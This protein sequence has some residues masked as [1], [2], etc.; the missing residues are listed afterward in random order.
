MPIDGIAR[1]FRTMLRLLVAGLAVG[2]VCPQSVAIGS[3]KSGIELISSG[4]SRVVFETTIEAYTLKPSARLENTMDLMVPGFATLSRPGEPRLPARKFLVALPPEG[5]YTVRASVLQEKSLGT[6]ILEPVAFPHIEH[7][8]YTQ[9]L[10]TEEYSIDES[11][12]RAYANKAT[13]LPD[14]A[15]FLRHQRVL[16][17]WINP[18]RYDP[19]SGALTLATKIRIEVV[20]SGSRSGEASAR[21]EPVVEQPGWNRILSR[22]LVNPDAP[23]SWRIKERRFSAPASG[24]G[25]R[26]HLLPPGPLLKIQVR[27]TGMHRIRASVLAAQGFPSGTATENLRLFK[28]QYDADTMEENYIDVPVAVRE[29]PGGTP[30]VFDGGDYLLFYGLRLRDDPLQG[31]PIEKFSD[32]NVYW[33][34]ADAGAAMQPVA[35]RSGFVS[36]D[37]SLVSFNVSDRYEEDHGFLEQTPKPAEGEPLLQQ[38]SYYFN[39]GYQ[40]SFQLPFTVPAIRSGSSVLVRIELTGGVLSE[41]SLRELVL[42]IVNSKG[43][44]PLNSIYVSGNNK[45]SYVSQPVPAAAIDIGTNTLR[46]LPE[47][48]KTQVEAF[49]NRFYI[50]YVSPYRARGSMLK[51]DT[52]SLAGDTSVTVTGLSRTDLLLFDV[53]DPFGARRCVLT[54]DLFTGTGGDTILS[55]RDA[56]AARKRYIL[57]PFDAIEEIGSSD[58]VSDTPSAIIGNPMEHG[59]DVLVVSHRDFMNEMQRWVGYRRAQGY[60]VFMVDVAELFDEFNGGV[61]NANAV[62]RFIEHYYRKADASVVLLVGD[63]S[64]D[65]K[66]VLPKSGP[67][68]VPTQSYPERT[69]SYPFNEDGVV[70]TDKW[71]VLMNN[72]FLAGQNDYYPDLLIGR[73]PAGDVRELQAML[74]KVFAFEKPG[75]SDF[76]R[77]RMIQVADDAW[78]GDL[79]TTCF[80]SSELGFEAGED[81]VEQIIE[82]SLAGG[83]DIVSA[84]LSNYTSI[85]HPVN[86]GCMSAYDARRF[87]RTQATPGL[88]AELSQGATLV[89]IQAHM[90][91]YLITHEEFFT[92]SQSTSTADGGQDHRRLQNFFKPFVVFGMGCHMSDYAANNELAR[93]QFNDANGD[94][95]DEL[96]LFLANRGAVS[97]YGSSGFE[98]LGENVVYTQRIFDTFFNNPPVD[99]MIA[100]NRAQARWIFGELMAVSEVTGATRG[101]LVRYHILGDPLL[102]IDAGPPRFSVTVNGT[103]VSSG[104]LVRTGSLNDTIHV[105][106]VVS[107]ENAID[108]L[109]LVIDGIDRSETL[110]EVPLVDGGLSA[111]RQYRVTFAHK[112][113]PKSYDIVLRALQ[114]PDTVS[115]QYNMAAEFTLTVPLDVTFQVNGRGIVDGDL[116]PIE[117]AYTVT[118]RVPVAVDAG[119]LGVSVDDV[120]VAP[121]TVNHPSPEDTTSWI[122]GFTKSLEAGEHT[123]AVS[124]AG[125]EIKHIAV[126]VSLERGIAEL[127]PYPNP[128]ST[129]AYFVFR[130]E[131]EIT[132]GRIEIFTTSGKRIANIPIPRTSMM[133]GQNAVRWDGR[134]QAGDR[135]A[136]GVYLYIATIFQ[137]TERFT[138]KGKIAHID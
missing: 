50:D 7:G 54:G 106:A 4:E 95:L 15:A 59:V 36:A 82:G 120:P 81:N 113:L 137:G 32:H 40:T 128:F 35:M 5:K 9:P 11:I 34:S 77:R 43:T 96:I 134:D 61:P 23:A 129:D 76:W 65:N 119:D 110:T 100:S 26:A 122:L 8:D 30:D 57:T 39:S 28:R 123:I 45:I 75:A 10:L 79:S 70:T 115:N 27:S 25:G 105:E 18:A 126:R 19:A 69:T 138:L 112:L 92:S 99:T 107:D 64:E 68:F 22:V 29:D 104:D 111:A 124:V 46:I 114:A 121:L 33:L 48:G 85:L 80:R 86:S 12:Y 44:F 55:F 89:S 108:S 131:V 90:N 71:Y 3:P 133:P 42:S 102:R 88:L 135:I 51:F 116:V 136:N 117:G 94:C 98:Y 37:T 130:N 74:D 24:A 56:L 84:Y 14:S 49:I 16:P 101:Q 97:T 38:D 21:Y 103:P 17:L 78:S 63:A 73:L 91:R 66:H 41:T 52:G 1:R 125:V 6:Y 83:Y 20:F 93:F 132:D 62:K 109:A 127:I 31:D 118:L 58:I 47:A 72:D 53:S 13:V 2:L 87:T 60:R 67:N